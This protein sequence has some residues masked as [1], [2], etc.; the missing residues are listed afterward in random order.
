MTTRGRELDK[1]MARGLTFLHEVQRDDGGFA[2]Q[3]SPLRHPFRPVH[4]YDT[5]FVP[6]VLLGALA[7]IPEANKICAQLAKWLLAQRSP[8]WSFNYWAAGAPERHTMPYPDDLDDTFCALI[9]LRAHD[10]TIIDAQVLG[11]VARLLIAVESRVGG[12]YRTWLVG[13]DAPAIWQDVDLAVNSNIACFLQQVAQ[14]L[15]NVTTMLERAITHNEFR[16]PYY[17]SAYPLLYYA[18]RAYRGPRSSA[19]AA[20]IQKRRRGGHW[21][22][23]LNTALAVSALAE[24]GYTRGLGPAITALLAAQL[25]DGSWPAEPFC[26]DP[27][28][29]GKRFYNGAS[30]LTTALALE[31]LQH[32][33]NAPAA[34]A[35]SPS[36]PQAAHSQAKQPD[37]EAALVF[38]QAR[39]EARRLPA[40]LAEQLCSV[41]ERLAA[42]PS[43]NEIVLLPSLVASSLRGGAPTASTRMLG[44]ANLYGW[45]AYT[46]YDDMLDGEGDRRLLPAACVALRRSEAGFR[47]SLPKAAAYQALI[48]TIFDTIDAANAWEISA[49]RVPVAGK[50]ITI[51]ALPAF[52]RR[53][54]LAERS[55]G[56]VLPALGVLAQQGIDLTGAPAKA[57]MTGCKQ[58]LIARQL[59]D[60]LHDWEDDL[61]AG[62]ITYVVA[63]ILDAA[64]I[65]A[66]QYD[67]EALIRRF[68]PLFWQ[69]VLPTVS[70]TLL[71]HVALARQA[72][73]RSR[74][75]EEPSPFMLLVE[76][77]ETAMQ[78]TLAEQRQA[79]AFL[80]G[81]SGNHS[82]IM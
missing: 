6:A 13:P 75:L 14:P 43:G 5:T 54:R 31:A 24:Q 50:T 60:D 15:P 11:A 41:V 42:G 22:S 67:T 21:G 82:K 1:A 56:H 3:S 61:R 65:P 23:P 18:A 58:Y 33:R 46:I 36:G 80:A 10:A 59:H 74:L 64:A 9:G 53:Q 47:Q 34:Q 4:T 7:K 27:A 45:A 81:Y 25:P 66:G 12:P 19:L 72:L 78:H 48:P 29:R 55:L 37:D 20:V 26:I 71:R 38:A 35:G 62:C 51:G 79:E 77:L 16:S 39:H 8:Q 32:C 49:C 76:K 44:L 28:R 2:S 52:G 68:Q 70:A 40:P 69:E 63:A 73:R 17:P 57:F 30:A